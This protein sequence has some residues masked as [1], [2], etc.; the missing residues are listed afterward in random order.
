MEYVYRLNISSKKFIN[1]TCYVLSQGMTIVFFGEDSLK[2]RLDEV[3][4]G[5]KA[6]SRILIHTSDL[7][8]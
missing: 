4:R 5:F 2:D 8:G 6:V 1:F 3:C 7:I